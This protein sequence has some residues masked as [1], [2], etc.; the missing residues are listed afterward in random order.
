MAFLLTDKLKTKQ[1]KKTNFHF[2][3]GWDSFQLPG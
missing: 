3:P 1:G 2:Y